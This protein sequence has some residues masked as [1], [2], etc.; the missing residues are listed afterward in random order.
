MAT[1]HLITI[2]RIKADHAGRFRGRRLHTNSTNKQ[3]DKCE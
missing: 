1:D 2:N 3:H